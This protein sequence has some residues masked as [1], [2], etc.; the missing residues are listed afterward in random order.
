[1]NDMIRI[2]LAQKQRS[3]ILWVN[4][5]GGQGGEERRPSDLQGTLGDVFRVPFSFSACDWLSRSWERWTVFTGTARRS[6]PAALLFSFLLFRGRVSRGTDYL[7]FCPPRFTTRT[8]LSRLWRR[9]RRKRR[10][11]ARLS[12]RSV[13]F[14]CR[15][16]SPETAPLRHGL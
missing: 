11:L 14:S 3:N 5:L 10:Q 2:L 1:M 7:L 9:S 13:A 16:S 4:K 6:R 12:P 8:R 15:S